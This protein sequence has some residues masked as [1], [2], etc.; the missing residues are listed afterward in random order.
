MLKAAR[1][2]MLVLRWT[3]VAQALD[4]FP[5]TAG[6]ADLARVT[7]RTGWEHRAT[8]REVLSEDEFRSIVTLLATQEV[9]DD[10]RVDAIDVSSALTV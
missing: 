4:T 7:E 1:V 8:I 6:Y 10:S 2:T 9:V 3:Y 5:T